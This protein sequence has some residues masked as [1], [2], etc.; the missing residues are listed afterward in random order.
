MSLRWG[1]DNCFYISFTPSTVIC[2]GFSLVTNVLNVSCFGQKRLLNALNVNVDVPVRVIIRTD[3]IGL[4]GVSAQAIMITLVLWLSF[5]QVYSIFVNK[6]RSS[7]FVSGITQKLLNEFPWNFDGEWVSPRI[8]PNNFGTNTDK[9]THPGNVFGCLKEDYFTLKPQTVAKASC[10]STY[11]FS[12][13]YSTV[14]VYI[15][16]EHSLILMCFHRPCCRPTTLWPMK[17]TVTRL[18]GW[19]LHPPRPT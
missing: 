4:H 19:L 14:F 2:R 6:K 7:W 12:Y 16:S 1:L 5:S 13:A 17:F 15:K 3:S 8:E 11:Y 9:G 10:H 18:W